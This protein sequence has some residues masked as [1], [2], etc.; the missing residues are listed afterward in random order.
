MNHF[1]EVALDSADSPELVGLAEEM[2]RC[3]ES[4]EHVIVR[5]PGG[6]LALMTPVS[7]E[8]NL[9]LKAETASAMCDH[10]FVDS[11]RRSLDQYERGDRGTPLPLGVRPGDQSLPLGDA[12]ILSS[13]ERGMRD[14]VEGR[15][16]CLKPG[17]RPE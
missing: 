14:Y 4:G 9:Q 3:G 11:L 15:G 5:L 12:E 13:L 6:R 7:P 16:R 2:E 1:R 17:E 10:L 8:D